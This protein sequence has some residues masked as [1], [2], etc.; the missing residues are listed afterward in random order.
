MSYEYLLCLTLNNLF[1]AF[2]LR[3]CHRM[4]LFDDDAYRA[5]LS[6]SLDNLSRGA[7]PNEDV[8]Q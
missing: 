2:V 3:E 5:Y 6:E 7:A 4:G 1:N 8:E